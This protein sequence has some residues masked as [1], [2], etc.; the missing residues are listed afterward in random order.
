IA[1]NGWDS[2]QASWLESTLQDADAHA[3]YTLV[4]RHHPEGDSSVT[5]NAASMQ[6][7]RA[8]KF[9]LLLT[10]HSHLYRHMTTDSGRDLVLGIGGAPLATSGAFNGYAMVDQLADGK[11]QISVYNL[12][13]NLQTDSWTVGPN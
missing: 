11:L 12:A 7:I 9:A 4:I 1:D 5:T 2:A 3:K 6:I 10:G 13:G 8:H